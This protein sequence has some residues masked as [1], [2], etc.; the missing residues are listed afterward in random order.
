MAFT[1]AS[2]LESTLLNE[3]V[4]VIKPKYP[5]PALP[6][7]LY[8]HGNTGDSSEPLRP[9]LYALFNALTDAGYTILSS[10]WTG[11][12]NWANESTILKINDGKTYLQNTLGAKAGK[13]IVI[14]SS[15]GA[16]AAMVWA[17]R[18]PNAVACVVGMLPVSDLSDIVTNNRGGAAPSV[19]SAYPGAWNDTVY[20]PTHN[21]L[22]I[23]QNGGLNR[24]KM[25]LFNGDS[26]TTVIPSTVQALASAAEANTVLTSVPGGHAWATYAAINPADVLSFIKAN[27]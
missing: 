17:S 1:A 10:L 7:I 11:T 13:V 18:Y 12:S 20:G 22:V 21:P 16:A 3:V 5:N 8:L 4:T 6:G 24:V 9:E 15:A 27:S 14:G 2:G 25:R 23:A 26:D 19:N